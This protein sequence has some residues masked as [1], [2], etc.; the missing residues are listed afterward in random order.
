MLDAIALHEAYKLGDM[1]AVRAL[2][3]D[4]PDFPNC[5]GPAGMGENIL[6]YAIYWSPPRFIRELLELGADPNY[7]DGAGFPSVVA[8]LS[9]ERI[10]KHE[11]AE[12]LLDF[13]ADVHQRGLNDYTPLHWAAGA[14]DLTLIELL[15][16]RGADPFAQTNIDDYETPL[17]LAEGRG[18]AGAVTLMRNFVA[19]KGT[20]FMHVDWQKAIQR[21]DAAAVRSMLADSRHLNSKDKHGQTGLM[22]AAKDGH[23][24]VA[25]LLIDHSADL[26]VTAKYHLSALMLAVLNRH[27]EI[28]ELLVNAGADKTIRG[29]GAPGF[30][31]LTAL[32]LAEKAGYGEI[33]SVLRHD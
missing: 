17:E 8:L 22:V 19:G 15:L 9:T 2:L 32:D 7:D 1:A 28:V 12:S 14:G 29:S 11:I 4:P 18:H 20:T 24:E 30:A 25:G 3:G 33:A 21:G 23:T 26:N 5:R 31:G 10:D 13:G 6:E 16:S 27:K